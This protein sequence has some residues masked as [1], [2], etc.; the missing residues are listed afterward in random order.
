M[1]QAKNKKQ[2]E[3]PAKGGIITPE[4][5]G[6]GR[7]SSIA[8][9]VDC[10]HNPFNPANYD[11]LFDALEAKVIGSLTRKLADGLTPAQLREL[12]ALG[13]KG[14]EFEFHADQAWRIHG[15]G[16]LEKWI[17]AGFH[18]EWK[19]DEQVLLRHVQT[20]RP[21]LLE[22][23]EIKDGTTCT[24]VDLLEPGEPFLLIDRSMAAQACRYQLGLCWTYDVPGGRRLSGAMSTPPHVDGL[25]PVEMLAALAA[26][27]GAPSGLPREWLLE[28]MGLLA[29]AFNA[30]ATAKRLAAV[31]VSDLRRFTLRFPVM[32]GRTSDIAGL[33]SANPR[34]FVEEEGPA[35]SASLLVEGADRDRDEEAEVIGELRLEADELVVESFGAKRADAVRALLAPMGLPV[36]Q[37]RC[38]AVDAGAA[39]AGKTYDRDLVPAAFLADPSPL[40]FPTTVRLREGGDGDVSDLAVIYRGFADKPNE[41]LGGKT[42]RELAADPA[43]RPR[44][45]RLMKNFITS[46]DRQRRTNGIDFDFNVVLREL[47]LD[48]LILP[49]PPLGFTGEEEEFDDDIPL[50]PPPPQDLLEGESLENRLDRVISDEALWN[51]LE[52]RLA[53]ILDAFNDLPDKLNPNELD[54]LQS[55]VL[56]ALG[57]LHP[58]QPPGY[59]PD[60]ERMLFRYESWMK[61]GD[62]QESLGDFLDR[63]F[64]E[65]RQP[66]LCEA[67]V[68][69]L[70]FMEKQSGKKLRPKKLDALFT[71][72]AAAVWEAAHWPPQ[73]E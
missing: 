52:I 43:M 42:P 55:A 51:R 62:D 14:N 66:A 68:D 69:L 61:S 35:F 40:D 25:E 38:D 72:V 47:G 57:A 2:R 16:L 64:A 71:A 28:H 23:R 50:D 26:H 1:G 3:C 34:V 65:T 9:P 15:T 29:E 13:A 48:E 70:M 41:G 53:D 24:A 32:K 21:S 20:M 18:R 10:P 67:A 8:C 27:L 5:C 6:R 46:C 37:E 19:N 22:I 11:S 59:D 36:G 63:I 39:L 60:P 44:L 56:A 33:L 58:D 31:K 73:R 12:G 45:L 49:P 54:A 17:D 7:N 30:I 4:D